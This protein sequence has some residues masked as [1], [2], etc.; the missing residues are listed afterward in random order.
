MDFIGN[1][2]SLSV[3][4]REEFFIDVARVLDERALQAMI[5]GNR[6]FAQFSKH[7][8]E[9]IFVNADELARDEAKTAAY[10]IGQASE[11][12]KQFD[13]YHPHRM[14]SYSMH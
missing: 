14:Q 6:K 12:L 10:V 5:E 9:A 3:E 2:E 7:M 13:A 1:L 8:A 4:E 11:L